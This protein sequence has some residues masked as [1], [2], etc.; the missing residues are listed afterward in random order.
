MSDEDQYAA[1]CERFRKAGFTAERLAELRAERLS[2]SDMALYGMGK[3]R[4]LSAL[5]RAYERLM[6][7]FREGERT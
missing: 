5:R 2:E 3:P 1:H 4:Q 7:L 6:R